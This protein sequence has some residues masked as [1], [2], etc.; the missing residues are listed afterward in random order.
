VI[1]N[2]YL[3]QNRDGEWLPTN[4]RFIYQTPWI[5]FYDRLIPLLSS[6]Q[7][8]DVSTINSN[9]F[10]APQVRTMLENMTQ[11]FAALMQDVE[12]DLL[13]KFHAEY[14]YTMVNAAFN[15]QLPVLLL[16]SV[17]VAAKDHGAA[18]AV[19]IA[20]ALDQWLK[21]HDPESNAAQFTFALTVF[22]D[23]NSRPVL[24]VPLYLLLSNLTE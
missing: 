11:L 13:I 22:S 2:Q 7:A 8:V 5:R 4:P 18:L 16:P 15:I 6:N 12:N 24:Q 9:I 21:G 20:G 17:T 19:I 23:D 14:E 10:P 3:L 1:R